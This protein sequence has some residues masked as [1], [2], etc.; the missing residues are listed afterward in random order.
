MASRLK[1]HLNKHC[2]RFDNI[3]KA[4]ARKRE[5]AEARG[6]RTKLGDET[7]MTEIV[8]PV[9]KQ[10]E[11]ITAEAHFDAR[12]SYILGLV[13]A[14]VE[15]L[16]GKP[17]AAETDEAQTHFRLQIPLDITLNHYARA[18]RV[19]AS[20]PRDLALATMEKI[21]EATGTMWT[22]R[23]RGPKTGMDT[24]QSMMSERRCGLARGTR[25]KAASSTTT[26]TTSH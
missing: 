15:G 3:V 6:K 9:R 19:T 8:E 24:Q 1:R 4:K 23:V 7:E 10:P 12:W 20:L 17:N 18:K 14:S 21:Q 25:E 16:Q 2:I 11:T 13:R 22:E 26:A 5:A